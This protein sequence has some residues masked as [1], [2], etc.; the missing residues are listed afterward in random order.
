M[1]SGEPEQP[2]RSRKRPPIKKKILSKGLCGVG[3]EEMQSALSSL[4]ER[5]T[6]QLH[7]RREGKQIAHSSQNKLLLGKAKLLESIQPDREVKAP[8]TGLGLRSLPLASSEQAV[9]TGPH[10]TSADLSLHLEMGASQPALSDVEGKPEWKG[11]KE[12]N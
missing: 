9:A 7:I 4:Q 5:K 10:L 11:K 2:E 6:E 8:K 1:T 12:T 3:R